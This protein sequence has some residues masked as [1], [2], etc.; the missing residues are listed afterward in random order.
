MSLD[1]AAAVKAAAAIAREAGALQLGAR[2][3]VGDV[4]VEFKGR[5][6]LVTE[7]DRASE[8]LIVDRL[9]ERFPDHDIYAEEGERKEE[10]AS[11]YRW[12]I[13]PLDG[14]TNF[15][16]G[17]PMFCVA[18]G[19]EERRGPEESAIVGAVV[20]APALDEMFCARL[21]GGATLNG[22]PIRVS[23]TDDLLDA[24]LATG[25]AYVRDE[26]ENDNV[27]NWRR[28]VFET[29][30]L[31][32]F[33]S[34]AIDLAYVAAGRFDAYWEMHLQPYDVAAGALLVHEAGG[35]VSDTEGGD[36]WLFG[37]RVIASN[38]RLHAAIQERLAPVVDDGTIPFGA[39]P[40]ARFAAES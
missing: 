33:G 22:A 16:H 9:L 2:A 11:P 1:I 27:D 23:A 20:Y 39:R 3:G 15:A 31:R 8:R 14:T 32:R 40:R 25:F 12:I 37:R 24:V 7:V 21:G 35:L 17:L 38:G 34:A 29:R 4:K 13:D 28:M 30:G 5:V 10:R 18:L 36:E 6:E 19:L 26:T